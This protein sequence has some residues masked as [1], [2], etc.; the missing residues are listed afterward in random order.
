MDTSTRFRNNANGN[1]LF[2]SLTQIL[3]PLGNGDTVK[4]GNWAIQHYIDL[5]RTAAK[6]RLLVC[7]YELC[8]IRGGEDVLL[9]I[10]H[11]KMK[12]EAIERLLPMLND[13]KMLDALAMASYKTWASEIELLAFRALTGIDV[14][15]HY[16]QSYPDTSRSKYIILNTGR[17][18]FE[19]CR[20]KDGPENYWGVLREAKAKL[21]EKCKSLR[22]VPEELAQYANIEAIPLNRVSME[23]KGT[24]TCLGNAPP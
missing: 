12:E 15:S 11:D 5:P 6:I 16:P 4:S 23:S 2:E 7:M 1:C 18:H 14:D 21:T 8:V 10:T 3:V 22:I 20:P 13:V 24:V 9:E 17:S 19:L